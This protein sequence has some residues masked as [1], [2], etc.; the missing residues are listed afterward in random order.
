MSAIEQAHSAEPTPTSSP[1]DSPR[2]FLQFEL[3]T[4]AISELAN[5]Y[6]KPEK[7]TP[8]LE[9]HKSLFCLCPSLSQEHNP[10]SSLHI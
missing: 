5:E 9:E 1:P 10:F 3:N 4:G 6:V 8:L 2:K 7:L